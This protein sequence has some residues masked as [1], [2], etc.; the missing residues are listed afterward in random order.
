MPSTRIPAGAK[1][2][3]RDNQINLRASDKERAV[4]DYAATLVN[5]SRTDFILELVYNEAQNI[6]LDQRVFMLDDERYAAFIQQLEAPL[7]NIE[8]RNRLKDVKPEWE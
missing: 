5:K 3:P 6:I 8:G 2:L 1:K 4:I 7:E